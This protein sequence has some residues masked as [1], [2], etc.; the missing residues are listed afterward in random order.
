MNILC[1]SLLLILC[2][3][4]ETSFAMD[5][6]NSPQCYR[7]AERVVDKS[8]DAG[9]YDKNGFTTEECVLA[10]NKM[11]VLCSVR[12]SKGQGAANDAYLA[13]LNRNCT[14]KFRVVLVGEE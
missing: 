4:S 7:M 2:L 5:S 11:A 13:V 3:F 8:V 14:K 12:A 9:K 6:S 10:N 1:S